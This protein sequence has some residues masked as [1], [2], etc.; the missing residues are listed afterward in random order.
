[1]TYFKRSTELFP[2]EAIVL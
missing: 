1:M 2:F